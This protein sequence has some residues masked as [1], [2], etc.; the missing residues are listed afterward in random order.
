MC[1]VAYMNNPSTVSVVPDDAGLAQL[2]AYQREHIEWLKSLD[3]STARSEQVL[4][5]LQALD[6]QMNRK[7]GERLYAHE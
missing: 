2:I 4:S 1:W 5:V 7:A 3:R 6:R